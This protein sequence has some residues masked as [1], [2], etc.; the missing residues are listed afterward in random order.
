MAAAA[1]SP[2][3]G[4]H[5]RRLLTVTDVAKLLQLSSRS[6]RRLIAD[7]RLKVVRLGRTIRIRPEDLEVLMASSGREVSEN[8]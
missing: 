4:G 7:G 2:S 1:S 3:S 6:V 5:L 8:D